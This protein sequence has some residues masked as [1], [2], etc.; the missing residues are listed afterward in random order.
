MRRKF[1]MG[2]QRFFFEKRTF[3]NFSFLFPLAFWSDQTRILGVL[4]FL[5]VKRGCVLDT[6]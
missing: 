5:S 3:H 6:F 4:R 2:K 1:L